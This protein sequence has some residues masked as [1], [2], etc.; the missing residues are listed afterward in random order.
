MTSG[1]VRARGRRKAGCLV[2]KRIV[3]RDT[4]TDVCL[5]ERQT[6]YA[7]LKSGGVSGMRGGEMDGCSKPY[8][9]RQTEHE[10]SPGD[11]SPVFVHRI[12]HNRHA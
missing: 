7:G 9:D 11:P 4:G 12:H 1:K 5:G 6:G 3:D 8:R 2:G 10:R